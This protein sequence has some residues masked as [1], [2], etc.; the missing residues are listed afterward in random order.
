MI[1]LSIKNVPT[2]YKII[3]LKYKNLYKTLTFF[4]VKLVNLLLL[5]GKTM[6]PF[7]IL[8]NTKLNN[9]ILFGY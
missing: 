8:F 1:L 7:S 6:F 3:S 5:V 4:N 2:K 9:H